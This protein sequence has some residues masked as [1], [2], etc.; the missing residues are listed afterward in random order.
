MTLRAAV[1]KEIKGRKVKGEITPELWI[2][3]GPWV[4]EV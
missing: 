1:K 3:G 2:D 4:V